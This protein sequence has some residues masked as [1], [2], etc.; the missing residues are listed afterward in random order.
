[1]FHAFAHTLKI[2][3]NEDHYSEFKKRKSFQFLEQFY[4]KVQPKTV[5]ERLKIDCLNKCDYFNLPPLYTVYPWQKI[6]HLTYYN[7]SVQIMKEE[8]EKQTK[9]KYKI[10][11]GNKFFGPVSYRMLKSEYDRLISV[12]N[13]IK[14]KGYINNNDIA[15]QLFVK[16]DEYLYQ[17]TNGIHRISSLIALG[18][19]SFP[20][21]MSIGKTDVINRANYKEWEHVKSGLYTEEQALLIFDN[22]FK[23]MIDN[24]DTP[25]YGI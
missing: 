8:F 6:N 21:L 20:L 9:F 4:L 3:E 16:D 11:D 19:E 25:I 2:Y 10:E 23:P 18:F 14:T 17:A 1:M 22:A 24:L 7:S 5:A 12:Y 13:S 15:I